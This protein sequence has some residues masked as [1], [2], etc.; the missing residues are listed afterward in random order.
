MKYSLRIIPAAEREMRNLPSL[1]LRR[2]HLRILR[3]QENPFAP[4]TRKLSR[5]LGYRVRVGGYRII[6]TVEEDNRAV[7]ITAVRHRRDA[8]R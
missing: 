2:V 5:R 3:L 6:F 8:Y 7:V 1:T 4:G